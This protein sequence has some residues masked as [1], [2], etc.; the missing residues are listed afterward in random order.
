MAAAL[1]ATAKATIIHSHTNPLDLTTPVDALSKTIANA[2]TSG[3]GANK[4][5]LVWSDR[6]SLAAAASETIDLFDLAIDGGAAQL[7]ALGLAFANLALKALCIQIV[8][9]SGNAIATPVAGEI[10]KIGGEGSAAAW[11]SMFHVSGTLSDTAGMTIAPAGT[12]LVIAP[13][14]LGQPVADTSNHLLKITNSGAAI[15]YYNI[16]ILGT[17]AAS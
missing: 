4:A 13:S 16:W 6:R 11:Q 12:L 1:T 10:M 8:D 5:N 15:M 17:T 3:T 14:A 9:S 2:F 7:D